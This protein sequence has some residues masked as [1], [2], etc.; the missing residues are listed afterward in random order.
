M[1]VNVTEATDDGLTAVAKVGPL[2]A[3]AAEAHDVPLDVRTL[4]L[5]DGAT[6]VIADVPAP[7]RTLLAVWV[8]APVPPCA[9]DRSVVR[10]VSAV[11]SELLPSSQGK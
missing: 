9:T 1:P 10:P 2:E 3:A 11:M 8:D 5:V 6:D 4:P 7:T